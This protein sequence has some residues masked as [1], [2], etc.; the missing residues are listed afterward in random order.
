MKKWLKYLIVIVLLLIIFG[1]I[2]CY[3][4]PF[5]RLKGDKVID[6]EVGNEYQ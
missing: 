3:N 5:F 4:V 1:F 6:L 2:Y